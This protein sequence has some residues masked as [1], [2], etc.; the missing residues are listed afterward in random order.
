[1]IVMGILITLAVLA[2]ITQ[3]GVYL[4][5]RRHPPAGR[6]IDVAGGSL[7]VVDIGP[8]SS[9]L[10]PAVLLHGASSNLESMRQPLGDMLAKDRRVILL[11]RPGH[12]WSTR[13]SLRAAT[14]ARQA[15]MIDEA[16]EKLG[17]ASA[18][19][20][21]HS[22]GGALAPA[23]A[24]HNPRRVAGLVM[25]APVTHPWEGGVAWYHD[26]GVLPV[27]GPLFA[28]T[29]ELPAGLAMLGPGARVAFLPQSAPDNYVHDTALALLLR[30]REYLA[31]AWDMAT[32]NDAM[33]IQSQRY[34][35]I[36]APA[37]LLHGDA[38]KA[39]SIDIHARQFIKD[40]RG[41]RL[42]TLNGIGHLVPNAATRLVLDAVNEVS[43]LAVVK[44]AAAAE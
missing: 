33:T 29:L 26:L 16:L 39:V 10:P 32:L 31:N 1:M 40:A 3:A 25:L 19:V 7:H 9:P 27:I 20:V 24:I 44:P 8:K 17:I 11:D 6:I 5:E 42:V 13:D 28:Y 38:D 36:T 14:P 23:L 30:P 4:I 34:G 21:G 15:E 2:A 37:I 12:G 43:E 22:W 41:A 35:E 18:I